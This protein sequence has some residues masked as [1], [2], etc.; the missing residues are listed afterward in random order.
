MLRSLFL[1]LAL[2]GCA[3]AAH[4]QAS[5][6]EALNYPLACDA[7]S[8]R[9]CPLGGCTSA[10]PG[11]ETQIPISLSIPVHSDIGR[12]CIATGCEDAR[13]AQKASASPAWT[14]DVATG[15]GF[16]HPVG[17]LQVSRD[18]QSFTLVQP[19]SDGATIWAGFCR[20]AGS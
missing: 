7:A 12:F 5:A 1:A 9:V 11:E 8:A 18:R 10:N 15:P 16:F 6:P 3:S 13:Y 4:E 2:A 14:A 19:A 17:E 20:A